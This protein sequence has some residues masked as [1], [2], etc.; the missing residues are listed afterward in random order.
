VIFDESGLYEYM[1]LGVP[2]GN[3]TK[4][5]IDTDN[6][7]YLKTIHKRGYTDD[8]IHFPK[9]RKC[10]SLGELSKCYGINFIK[11]GTIK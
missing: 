3:I 9:S 7:Y 10:S 5:C 6:Q 11:V 2:T 8:N 1:E 4:V